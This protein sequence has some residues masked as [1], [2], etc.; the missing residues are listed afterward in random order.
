[1]LLREGRAVVHQLKPFTIRLKDR[2]L[3]DSELQPIRV[4]IDPGSKTTGIAVIRE[5]D[6]ESGS[7]QFLA[8]IHHR[9]NIKMKMGTRRAARH[10]RRS[11]NL[12][13]RKP[14]FLNRTRPEG[15]LPPSM[16]SKADNILSWVSRLQKWVPVTSL[17][18]E[19]ARFDTQLMQNPEI[20][21]VEYQQGELQGYEVREYLLEKWGRKCAYCGIDNLPLEVE[22]MVPKSR[23]GSNRISNLTLACRPCNEE[24]DRL[25][26]EEYGK[27]KSKDFTHITHQAEQ[28]LREAAHVNSTRRFLEQKLI[29]LLPLEVGTGGLTKYNRTSRGFPKTHYYDALCVGENTPKYI[30][31]QT[32]LVMDIKAFGRG[33]RFRSRLDRYGFP[34]GYLTNQ[35]QVMG[36]QTGDLVKAVVRSGKK[37]GTYIGRVAIR[38]TGS[39]NIR[40]ITDVVEGISWRCCLQMAMAMATKG[41]KLP[42][43]PQLKSGVSG[44]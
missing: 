29:K 12:R 17:S 14:R 15:W 32:D 25:T 28:P 4:K 26:T 42:S 23:G 39:F 34:R 43:S 37:Q 11:A 19:T 35:K 36:F 27:L 30:K 7:V 21:G 1:M 9:Q 13:Y 16:K 18:L 5:D 20:S 2:L 38:A 6:E 3:E 24:K 10:R 22:H 44:G 31:H 41:G 40:T 8:N 33:S